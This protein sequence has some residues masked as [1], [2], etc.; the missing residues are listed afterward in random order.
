MTNYRK[1]YDGEDQTT[2]PEEIMSWFPSKLKKMVQDRIDKKMEET[3]GLDPTLD[4]EEIQ[5][6]ADDI[7]E[8]AANVLSTE[9][10]KKGS[11]EFYARQKNEL[12]GRA[13]DTI[14]YYDFNLP[15]IMNKRKESLMSKNKDMSS[16][17]LLSAVVKNSTEKHNDEDSKEKSDG[18]SNADAS[19]SRGGRGGRGG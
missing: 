16:P 10:A 19:S 1:R 3:L 15:T 5:P 4:H 2:I 18:K 12:N 17:A 9:Q 6:T 11:V 14:I 8:F 7:W 13:F